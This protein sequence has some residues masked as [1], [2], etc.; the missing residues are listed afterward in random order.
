MS[1]SR[2][3]F[4]LFCTVAALLGVFA[5]VSVAIFEQVDSGNGELIDKRMYVFSKVLAIVNDAKSLEAAGSHFL[6]TGKKEAYQRFIDSHM[7][8]RAG[9]KA[10]IEDP[11][12]AE[13]K[14]ELEAIAAL[15]IRAEEVGHEAFRRRLV[16]MYSAERAGGYLEATGLPI[17]L[18]MQRRLREL[19][20]V[21]LRS[22]QE[23]STEARN[24]Q[25]YA[26]EVILYTLAGVAVLVVLLIFSLSAILRQKDLLDHKRNELLEREK[27]LSMAR[28]E[29][30]EIVAHDLRSP[31]SSVKMCLEM[32][33]DEPDGAER[34]KLKD[35]ASRSLGNAIV[36]IEQVLDHSKIESD[37]MARELMEC[38]FR[39]FLEEQA[40]IFS[41]LC[42]SNGVVF[43]A[44]IS[45][46]LGS[47]PCDRTKLCQVLSNLI[48]NALKFTPKG[49]AISLRAI[50]QDGEVL[51]HVEDQGPGISRDHISRVFDRYWR[52]PAARYGGLGLGLAVSKA[53]VDAHGGRIWVE[54]DLGKGSSFYFTL[55]LV[56]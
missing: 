41:A 20:G 44:S 11:R 18:D 35:I 46:T 47:A 24:T 10:L 2:K 43:R 8:L 30:V 21:T 19:E 36:L 52:D 6:I 23:S 16:G 34:S 54:S 15:E 7:H 45:E 12:C 49:A 39:E 5:F 40:T 56:Q 55:P 33:D 38:E 31:L 48:G 17:V 25:A 9:L 32:I 3:V 50:V 53:I 42:A 51:I 1:F 13:Y 26:E 14:T 28:K 4:L 29:A 37:R 27:G 22:W